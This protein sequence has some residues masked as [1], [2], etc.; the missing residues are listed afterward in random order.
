MATI[1]ADL[2]MLPEQFDLTYIDEHGPAAAGRSR[3][4]AR[5]SARWS[6]SSG[7]SSSTSPGR[8]RCGSRR[9]RRWSSRSPTGTWT[10]PNELA[11]EL[12]AAGV[13]FVEV[14]ASDNRMQNKIRLA[15]GQKVPYMLILGDREVEARTASVRRRDGTQETGRGVGGPRLAPRRGGPL[16]GAG[17]TAGAPGSRATAL[18]RRS[19]R[20]AGSPGSLA[21]PSRESACRQSSSARRRHGALGDQ[22]A[23]SRL[24]ARRHVVRL[25]SEAEHR[26]S[27]PG[28]NVARRPGLVR[29]GSHAGRSPADPCAGDRR[30]WARRAAPSG[31]RA[32]SGR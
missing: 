16:P 15:Q 4:T 20:S 22:R 10:P 5:S 27:V 30:R 19:A 21:R 1:Q 28:S 7:S 18:Q 17:L 8:S 12:R 14:D 6:G 9:S 25:A 23:T 3:S 26:G 32:T 24:R 11:G 31:W 29:S 2:T 13:R